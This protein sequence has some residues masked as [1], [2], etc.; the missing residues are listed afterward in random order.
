MV[1]IETLIINTS[2][3]QITE[4]SIPENFKMSSNLTTCNE[5]PVLLTKVG[6]ANSTTFNSTNN[7]QPTIGPLN[8]DKFPSYFNHF[9]M[10]ADKNSRK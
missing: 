3:I 4:K 7:L 10:N 6:I 8:K 5:N 9:D 2:L 1:Q